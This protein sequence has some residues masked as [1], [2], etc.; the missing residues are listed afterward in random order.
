MN[1]KSI[2]VCFLMLF[3]VQVHAQENKYKSTST[4][5]YSDFVA[6]ENGNRL[7]GITILI[8]STW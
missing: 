2:F 5:Y 4:N 6:D 1:I 7:S 3:F 8:K